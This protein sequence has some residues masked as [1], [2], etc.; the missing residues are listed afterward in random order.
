MNN[1][2]ELN[3]YVMDIR[4]LENADLFAQA[5]CLL[6]PAR[7]EKAMR[8]KNEKDRARLAGAG[9]LLLL[10]HAGL[11]GS[12]RLT[13]GDIFCGKSMSDAAPKQAQKEGKKEREKEDIV[14]EEGLQILSPNLIIQTIVDEEEKR[15]YPMSEG[16]F[17]EISDR[18]RPTWR[19]RTGQAAYPY[20]N[21]SHSGHYAALAAGNV[22]VGIDIQEPREVRYPSIGDYR[23]FSRLE[24]YL[25]CTGQGFAHR[26]ETCY[27]E[28]EEAENSGGYCFWDIPMPDRYALWVCADVDDRK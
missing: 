19:L 28:L 26:I 20:F 14:S 2:M 7:K 13:D 3:L 1:I 22:L 16:I 18:G 17:Y 5:L 12:M 23:S 8:A 27:Q 11:N 6:D 21:L 4:E 24:S 25:K 10:A 15:G 9:L